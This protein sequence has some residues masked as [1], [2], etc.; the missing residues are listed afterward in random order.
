M[1]Q[2]TFHLCCGNDLVPFIGSFTINRDN[3][4][5]VIQ[6]LLFVYGVHKIGH[7]ETAE[8]ATDQLHQFN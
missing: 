8:E 7:C 2:G 1:N 3:L 6:N 4:D 5:L